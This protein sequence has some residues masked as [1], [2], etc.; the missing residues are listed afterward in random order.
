MRMLIRVGRGRGRRGEGGREVTLSC[1][2]GVVGRYIFSR[3]SCHISPFFYS[4]AI[5][6]DFP[7]ILFSIFRKKIAFHLCFFD[8]YLSL[9]VVSI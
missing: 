3:L 1:L 4:C 5:S 2:M 7:F 6:Y 8:R 9:S